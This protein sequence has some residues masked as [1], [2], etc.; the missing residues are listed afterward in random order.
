VADIKWAMV[1]VAGTP[2]RSWHA[3]SP[4]ELR[5]TRCG[6][7][8]SLGPVVDTLPAGRSCESCLRIVSREADVP[9]VT[10]EAT[11]PIEAEVEAED[12]VEVEDD[13]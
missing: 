1:R 8:A 2:G 10:Q 9:E 7:D 3:L 6:L 5:R 13:E 12:E 4:S 11:F